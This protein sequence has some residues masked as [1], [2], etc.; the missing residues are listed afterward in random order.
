MFISLRPLVAQFRFCT[1]SQGAQVQFL[2]RELRTP[3]LQGVAKE[4]MVYSVF[5]S[6]VVCES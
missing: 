5:I 4:K 1:S 3:R 2:V 6:F